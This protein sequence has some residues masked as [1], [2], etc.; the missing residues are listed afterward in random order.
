VGDHDSSFSRGMPQC[1]NCDP[2]LNPLKDQQRS[3][4]GVL[5]TPLT[6]YS[7]HCV[8]LKDLGLTYESMPPY[9]IMRDPTLGLV[10]FTGERDGN[11]IPE[12]FEQ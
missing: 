2:N 9:F 7:A 11:L 12:R 10:A 3:A 6:L 5:D 1:G 4:C 8:L